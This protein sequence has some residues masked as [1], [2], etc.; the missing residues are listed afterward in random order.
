MARVFD[1]A[2][3]A[4]RVCPVLALFARACP[5][6][7]EVAG[8]DAAGTMRFSQRLQPALQAASCPPFAENGGWPRRLISLAGRVARLSNCRSHHRCGCPVLR[9]GEKGG[10]DDGI[11]SG[12]CRTDKSCAG[13]IAAHPF[14]KLSRSLT[15]KSFSFCQY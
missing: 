2:S 1:P 9:V 5:E 10:Y 13:S 8:S 11:H 7:A 6:L 14:D 12:R 15:R 3:S 4:H